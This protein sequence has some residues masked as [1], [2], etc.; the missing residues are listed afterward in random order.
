MANRRTLIAALAMLMT[1]AALVHTQTV[2]QRYT[3]L[4]K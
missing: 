2:P 4:Q 1:G 3:T